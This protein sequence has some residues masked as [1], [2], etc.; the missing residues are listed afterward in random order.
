MPWGRLDQ[1]SGR[2][3][4]EARFSCHG[5][6]DRNRVDVSVMVY[7]A[8]NHFVVNCAILRQWKVVGFRGF[9]FLFLLERSSGRRF[10]RIS[11]RQVNKGRHG[12]LSDG[13]KEGLVN[14]KE[15]EGSVRREKVYK[16][17]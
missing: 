10:G 12:H 15:V 4:C 14:C 5:R 6:S 17:R 11:L 1:G 13:K 8:I 9:G 2:C 7:V 16:Q 3:R